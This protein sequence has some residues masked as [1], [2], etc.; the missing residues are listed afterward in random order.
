[1]MDGGSTA[2]RRKFS[3]EGAKFSSLGSELSVALQ[4]IRIGGRPLPDGA[5]ARNVTPRA[6]NGDVDEA[7]YARGAVT[8][9]YVSKG[10]AVEQIFVLDKTLESLRGGG[11][12]SVTVA[13]DTTLEPAIRRK[14]GV[15]GPETPVDR[16]EFKR[17][18]GSAAF[19][20]GGAVAIDATGRRR[21]LSYLVGEGR[22]EMVLDAG[23][24][25]G[26]EFPLT[27][28]PLIG[29]NFYVDGSGLIHQD[30]DVA[31]SP[32]ANAYLVVFEKN[33]GAGN[34]DIQCA[35]VTAAGVVS[36]TVDIDISAGKDSKRPRVARSG[37]NE[38]LVVWMEKS[39]GQFD[40]VGI[41]MKILAGIP[42]AVGTKFTIVTFTGGYSAINPSVGYSFSKNTYLVA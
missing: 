10:T 7:V 38:F 34:G 36:A 26:A 32:T 17:P 16:V 42:S 41:R 24:L 40:I 4:E 25:A 20:Y 35:A 12:L 3:P 11:E 9:K 5:F 1:S 15:A 6:G 14:E 2:F 28:D 13:L 33:A 22:L 18:D 27:I 30:L 39:G 31:F 29:V 19:T 21:A 37:S 8:E 23:F